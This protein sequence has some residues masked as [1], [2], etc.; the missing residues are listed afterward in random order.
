MTTLQII[1][2]CMLT[3]PFALLFV[4]ISDMEGVWTAATVF[5][6]SA[7]MTLFVTIACI[8]LAGGT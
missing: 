3:V 4:M 8:F 1:G 6:V 2:A 7:A 5:V